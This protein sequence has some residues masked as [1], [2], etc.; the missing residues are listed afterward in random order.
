M[1]P[2][3]EHFKAETSSGERNAIKKCKRCGWFLWDNGHGRCFNNG[4]LQRAYFWKLRISSMRHYNTL[5][6]LGSM[7]STSG[8]QGI[9]IGSPYQLTRLD[10]HT[11][12][13]ERRLSEVRFSCYLPPG[14]LLVLLLC[15]GI[16]LSWYESRL[17][18]STVRKAWKFHSR[19]DTA[20]HLML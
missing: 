11:K 13:A 7:L 20:L 8:S 15:L 10:C 17:L 4:C 18:T 3:S 5:S 14:R 16:G 9:P 12:D 19:V 2:D 6:T 1:A